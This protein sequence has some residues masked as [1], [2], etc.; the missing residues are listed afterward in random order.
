MIATDYLVV[1]AGASGL[2]FTDALINRADADV[3]MID[4]RAC[5]GGHWVHAYP[6]VRLHQPSATYGVDS[7]EL[8]TGRIDTSG[9]NAGYYELATGAEVADY[10]GRVLTEGLLPTGRV[11]F[12]PLS[13]YLGNDGN[14]HHF[15]SLL[16]GAVTDVKVRKRLMDATFIQP[17]VP[18]RHRPAFEV[19]AGVRFVSPNGLADLSEP[20]DRFTII[21]SG[22]TAMDTCGWLI[23]NGVAPDHIRWIKPREPLMLNRAF[24]QPRELVASYMQLLS[25]LVTAGAAAE[26]PLDF[27]ARLE[28]SGLLVRIHSDV[29]PSAFRG[30]TICMGEVERIR[31]VEHVVRKGHVRRI[32]RNEVTLVDGTIEA[33]PA[34]VFVDCTARGVPT[35]ALRPVFEPGR[36]TMEFVALGNAPY[37]AAIIGV[38]EAL[39]DDDVERN[40]LCPPMRFDGTLLSFPT[41]VL[42]A[43]AGSKARAAEPQFNAWNSS[44]R[45]NPIRGAA[46][47]RD[48]P[49]IAS[50]FAALAEHAGPAL[51]NL[52]R[53]AGL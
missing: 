12:F 49:A 44:S 5:A 34:E 4:R 16:T 35:T 50:A 7:R 8:G 31:Q 46:D 24:T 47:R 21:G 18:S 52:A 17:S 51:S 20:G 11:R 42:T 45:M 9:P 22:K 37:S 19:D 15:R 3:V 36:I 27:S 38:V 2:A 13:E 48:D 32:G 53:F 30:G 33:R 43:L 29:E 6:F 26:N 41:L 39:C 28:A 40:R 25:T 1:G 14:V 23:E 10:F